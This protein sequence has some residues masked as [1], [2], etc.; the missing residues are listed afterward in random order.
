MLKIEDLRIDYIT[1]EVDELI[2]EDEGL[3]EMKQKSFLIGW[4]AN[5]GW[6]T[7]SVWFD[8]DGKLIVDD[9]GLGEDFLELLLPLIPEYFRKFSGIKGEK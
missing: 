9:E 1:A 4:S 2:H 6:G 5:I 7:F 8:A 3:F